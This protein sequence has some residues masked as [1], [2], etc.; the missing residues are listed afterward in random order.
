VALC[1]DGCTIH[2]PQGI[3]IE[4]V[5]MRQT[6]SGPRAA[7]REI[8]GVEVLPTEELLGVECDIL[9]CASG[10]SVLHEDNVKKV[11]ARCV[12]EGLNDPVT[13]MAR[14]QLFKDGVLVLPSILAT[15]GGVISSYAEYN[16]NSSER[17][18]SMIGSKMRDVTTEVVAKALEQGIPPMRVAKERAKERILE[19]IENDQLPEGVE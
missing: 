1:D 11:K 9:V 12:V 15:A 4:S 3:D 18:F 16:S 6:K 13:P 17:A 8:E 5:P 7:I 19:S 10:S 14:Q 2:D